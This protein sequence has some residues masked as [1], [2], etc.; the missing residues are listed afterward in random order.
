MTRQEKDMAAPKHIHA[1]LAGD[2]RADEATV[3]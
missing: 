1:Q 3:S 2:K